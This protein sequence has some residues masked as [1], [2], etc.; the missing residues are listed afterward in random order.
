M[1]STARSS[2]VVVR[3][4]VSV[5]DLLTITR[6]TLRA[7]GR[8]VNYLFY[9]TRKL[10]RARNTTLEMVDCDWSVI[11]PLQSYFTSSVE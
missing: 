10:S 2:L 4:S 3:S 1:A 6:E 9:L 8:T 5:V 11:F 7:G